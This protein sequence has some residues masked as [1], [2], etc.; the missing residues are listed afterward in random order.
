M[1]SFICIFTLSLSFCAF[2]Q[3]FHT[4]SIWFEHAHS[5]RKYKI[6]L[7]QD[8]DSTKRYQTI[9]C[10]DADLLFNSLVSSTEIYSFPDIA[11]MPPTIVVGL[12][13]DQRN[14]DMGIESDKSQLNETGQAF[15]GLIKNQLIPE[16]EN[17]YAT[18]EYRAIV[19]HSNSST[20]IQFFLWE[21]EP[22]FQGYLS[23]SEYELKKDTEHFC[24]LSLTHPI[25]FTFVS[26]KKDAPYR[27]DSGLKHEAILDSCQPSNF[28]YKHI[29]LESADHLT[30][31]PQGIPLGLEE[32][33]TDYSSSLPNTDSLLKLIGSQNPV[34]LM[35]SLVKMKADKYDAHASYNFTE[36]DILFEL[37]VQTKDS[38]NIHLATQKYAEIFQDSS[39]YFY[40]AQ[41]LELMGANR[42]AE[43]AYLKHINYF[44]DPGVWSYKRLVWLYMSKV[45]NLDEALY[46]CEQ[47]YNALQEEE[48]LELIRKIG[49][50]DK[51]YQKKAD[52]LVKQ[53]SES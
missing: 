48:F 11:K 23:M 9:Y 27:Y 22:E 6:W 34:E 15:I 51:K 31:V 4:D 53:L 3:T 43:K 5:Y 10:L 18:S 44:P 46:W 14:D 24:S 52:K 25:D 12:Y 2:G 32:L 36:I 47:G 37:F 26:A 29:I 7:P 16:I 17:A 19:G 50:K 8:Y 41:C 13:F 28:N 1:K 30:M 33:Y 20:F 40:E 39:E 21:E 45:V 49:K 35:D 38:A 42:A